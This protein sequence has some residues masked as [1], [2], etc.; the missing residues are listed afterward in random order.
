MLRITLIKTSFNSALGLGN[1]NPDLPPNKSR[2]ESTKIEIT[3]LCRDLSFD[4]IDSSG[5]CSFSSDQPTV[6]WI[7]PFLV[8]SKNFHTSWIQS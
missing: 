1:F 3:P 6:T 2:Q 7:E 4:H 8:S 5:T